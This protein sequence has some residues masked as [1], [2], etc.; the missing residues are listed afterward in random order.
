MSGKRVFE[1]N[2]LFGCSDRTSGRAPAMMRS[3]IYVLIVWIER[4]DESTTEK[5]DRVKRNNRTVKINTMKRAIWWSSG[6]IMTDSRAQY[7][8]KRESRAPY[9]RGNNAIVQSNN[10]NR[11][12]EASPSLDRTGRVVIICL[13]LFDPFCRRSRAERPTGLAR[14]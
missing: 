9:D 1:P 5:N 10:A 11:I 4:Q 2:D 8:R 12:E 3:G 14:K 13:P 7:D 6:R